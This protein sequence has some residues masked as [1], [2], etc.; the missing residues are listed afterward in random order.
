MKYLICIAGFFVF[1][2]EMP[3]PEVTVV[4]EDVIEMINVRWIGRS[5]QLSTVNDTICVYSGSHFFFLQDDDPRCYG[6]PDG[7]AC[8]LIRLYSDRSTI[9]YTEIDYPN[10]IRSYVIENIADWAY[11]EIGN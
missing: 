4:E 10:T 3:T 11:E 2:C 5:I 9:E 7:T 8:G 6:T 1:G